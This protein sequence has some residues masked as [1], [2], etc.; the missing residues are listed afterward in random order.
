[1]NYLT[2]LIIRGVP[3]AGPESGVKFTI[4]QHLDLADFSIFGRRRFRNQ[5]KAKEG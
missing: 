2:Y 5:D 4:R 1:M 3:D